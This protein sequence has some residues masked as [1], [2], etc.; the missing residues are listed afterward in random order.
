MKIEIVDQR[1]SDECGCPEEDLIIGMCFL[2]IHLE[3]D[4]SGHLFLDMGDWDEEKLVECD[5]TIE[6]LR[7][8]AHDWVEQIHINTLEH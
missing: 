6:D 8:R 5:G 3:K 2:T 7:N 1:K 4:N